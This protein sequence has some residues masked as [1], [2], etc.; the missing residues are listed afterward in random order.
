MDQPDY[1][2]AGQ[3][4][5]DQEFKKGARM[6]HGSDIRFRWRLSTWA[7]VLV[8][9]LVATVPDPRAFYLTPLYPVGLDRAIGTSGSSG[10]GIVGYFAHVALLIAMLAARRRYIFFLVTVLLVILCV[11]NTR[12]CHEMLKELSRIT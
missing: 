4:V 1:K 9:A 7:A 2:R 6:H 8:L 12:G 3:I 5:Y 10:G 11:L